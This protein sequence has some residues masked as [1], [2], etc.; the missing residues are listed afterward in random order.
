[1]Q[2]GATISTIGHALVLGWTLLSFSARP[3]EAAPVES[4][5]VD[6]ISSTEFSQITAGVKT[7][8]KAETP[9][10]LVEKL[11]EDKPV[12]DPTPKVSEKQ[13]I[14]SASAQEAPPPP[15]EPEKKPPEK[16]VEDK[17]PEPKTDAI[18]EALKKEQAKKP[19]PPKPAPPKKP[20]QQKLDLSKIENKLALLDKREQR[21]NAATGATLNENPSLGADGRAATLSQNEIEALRSR[22]RECWDVPVGVV[23]ARDLFVVVR[24]QFR[25]DGSLDADPAVLNNISHPAFQVAAESALRAIRKCAP[26]SF[27]PVAKYDVW[28][29][30]EV[31]FDPREMFRG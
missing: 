8:P 9:K 30:I 11:G 7:A 16:K 14:V 19:D 5:P 21:R 24:I 10:P 29:D 13:E 17:K 20:P 28:K 27:M 31:K 4:L 26:Y 2:V 12:K 23:D 6:I 15:P 18:A 1:M 25:R 22:L 3:F